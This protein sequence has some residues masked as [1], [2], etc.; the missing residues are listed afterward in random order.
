[1]VRRQ[2]PAAHHDESRSQQVGMVL[3]DAA[4][5][6]ADQVDGLDGESVGGALLRGFGRTRRSAK[7]ERRCLGHRPL[8]VEQTPWRRTARTRLAGLGGDQ[9]LPAGSRRRMRRRDREQ[10]RTTRDRAA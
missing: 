4:L 1:G 3:P 10:T 2:W 9:A 5:W 6:S 7:T 8:A